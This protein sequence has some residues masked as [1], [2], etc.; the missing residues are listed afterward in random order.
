MLRDGIS[1]SIR[2][3]PCCTS[4][5]SSVLA[6]ASMG[7]LNLLVEVTSTIRHGT[8]K[9][10][11]VYTVVSVVQAQQ[12]G[13]SRSIIVVLRRCLTARMHAYDIGTSTN[14]LG[15]RRRCLS[16]S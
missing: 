2:G 16:A 6:H 13:M 15:L 12:G 9:L 5:V 1:P 8:M 3:S 4:V 7:C 10:L 14:Q 11:R